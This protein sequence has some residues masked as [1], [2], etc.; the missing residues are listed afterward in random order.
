MKD[1]TDGHSDFDGIS[2]TRDSKY[3]TYIPGDARIEGF[4]TINDLIARIA[5]LEKML[6][7]FS[8]STNG[9]K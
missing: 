4:G 7:E 3:Q 5:K 2:E 1:I 6:K 9:A 8:A